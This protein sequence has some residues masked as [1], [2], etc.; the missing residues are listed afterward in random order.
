MSAEDLSGPAELVLAGSVARRY[1]FDGRTKVQIAD[2]LGLSRFKVARLLEAARDKGLIRIEIGYP[3]TIDVDLSG[4]L[5]DAFQLRHAIVVDTADDHDASLRQQLGSAAA[6]LLTE[7]VTPSDVLGLAWARSVTAM[8]TQ[9]RRLP[10][11]PVVQLTGP[12]TRSAEGYNSVED[13]SSIDV[14]RAVARVSRGPAYMF[15]APFLVADATT[16]RAMRRQ[17]D[18]ARAFDKI[19]SVTKAVAGIGLWAPGLSTLYEAAAE[20]E[21]RELAHQGV[22]ADVSGVFFKADGTPIETSLNDRMV[23]ISYDQL[24]AV[25]EVIAIPYGVSKAPAVLAV[26]RSGVVNSLVTHASMA[27]ALLQVGTTGFQQS[28]SSPNG[29]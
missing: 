13:H 4:R 28:T 26:L 3:G 18:V 11:I 14:V 7:V 15:F 6:D 27:R 5:Q 23:G 16:A 19:G 2:E 24:R 8:A 17:P 9:L 20:Q 25:P 22:C 21:R 10:A 12:L 29:A 1:Y